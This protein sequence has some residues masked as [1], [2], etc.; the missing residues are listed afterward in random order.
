MEENN[1]ID[2]K[3]WKVPTSWNDITLKKFQ[4]IQKYYAD[5]EEDFDV[6]DV[7]T[8]LTDKTEDEINALPVEFLDIILTHLLFLQTPIEQK[9]PTNKINIGGE[10]YEI[11]TME[12]L[13]TGEYVATDTILKNDKYDYASILAVLCRKK[14]EVF[15]S[16]FEAETF[17]KRREM[18]ENVPI[19]EILA[20]IGF[21]LNCYLILQTPSLLY[22][23]VEDMLNLIQQ[24]IGNSRHLGVYK[25]SSMK[26]QVKKLKKS[27]KSI[28]ST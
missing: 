17:P 21:F 23:Q 22:S 4:E 27:L 15:D 1:I 19:T 8:I 7:L 12:K 18:F 10:E 26:W 6:R 13:K 28:K 14:G 5:K 9:E 3:E 2:F 25:K 11:N 20:I 24:N 16:K